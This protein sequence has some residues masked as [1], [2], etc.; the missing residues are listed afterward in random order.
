MDRVGIRDLRQHASRHLARVKA[1]ETIEVTERGRLIALLVPPNTEQ[2]AR[3]RLIAA[4]QIAPA[5]RPFQ[6][7]Q[8]VAPPR[9]A[10]DTRT[11]LDELRA[12]DS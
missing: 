4:G 2:T 10:P 5:A 7:P 11:A 9:S 3:E 6:L 12:E 1:G 8:P